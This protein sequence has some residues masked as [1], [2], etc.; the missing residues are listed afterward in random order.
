MT[1]GNWV[2][3]G[4]DLSWSI[5]NWGGIGL[6]LDW[7]I[8][9]WASVGSCFSWSMKVELGWYIASSGLELAQLLAGLLAIELLLGKF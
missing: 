7:T 3:I 8:Y 6:C 5:E 9:N 4:S 1:L 2:G